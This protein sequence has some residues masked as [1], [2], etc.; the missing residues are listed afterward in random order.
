MKATVPLAPGS[1]SRSADKHRHKDDPRRQPGHDDGQ[2]RT[3]IPRWQ[4][5]HELGEQDDH[6]QPDEGAFGA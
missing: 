1:N 4:K 2:S 6:D 5:L 3:A